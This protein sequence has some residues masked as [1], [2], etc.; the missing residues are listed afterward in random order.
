L[1]GF[2]VTFIGRFW[3]TAE[4]RVL[5]TQDLL[6]LLTTMLGGF[7]EHPSILPGS[8]KTGYGWLH[9]EAKVQRTTQSA[10]EVF[11]HSLGYL[12][13]IAPFGA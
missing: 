1:A 9:D 5:G 3:V 4:D 12:L 7:V 13:Y 8:Q 2:Q 11:P 6:S 10:E